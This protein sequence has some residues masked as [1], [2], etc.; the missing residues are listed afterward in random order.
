MKTGTNN[1]ANKSLKSLENLILVSCLLAATACA[2]LVGGS[3]RNKNSDIVF[4]LE[5]T[6]LAMLPLGRASM[7]RSEQPLHDE[8][9][10]RLQVGN[11]FAVLHLGF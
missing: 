2:L 1:A 6:F 11:C 4:H 8:V 9:H 10:R 3:V 7:I 5:Q